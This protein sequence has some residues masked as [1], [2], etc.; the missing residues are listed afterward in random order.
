MYKYS[1][2]LLAGPG[3]GGGEIKEYSRAVSLGCLL[4]SAYFE[5]INLAFALCGVHAIQHFHRLNNLLL[6][7]YSGSRLELSEFLNS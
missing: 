1:S 5:L 4:G 3:V 7:E 6:S 2:P